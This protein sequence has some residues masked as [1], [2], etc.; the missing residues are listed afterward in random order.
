MSVVTIVGSQWGDEGKGKVV[1]L[2]GDR[3]D[4]IVRY[5]GGN[6]AG[7]TLV[8]GGEKVV[9]H[10]IPAA[11]L[12][13]DKICIIEAGVVLDP[14]VFLEEVKGLTD[15]G[16]LKKTK[17]YI[18]ER[19]HV[20]MPYHKMLDKARDSQGGDGNSPKIGT[21]GRGIGPC[22]SDKIARIG[23]RCGD[24]FEPELLKQKLKELLPEKNHLLQ[25]YGHQPLELD[26]LF[27]EFM[28][29]GEKLK[30]MITD[31][32]TIIREAAEAGKNILFEGAQGVLLDIDN[33]S[34]PYVTSS[35]TVAGCVSTGGGFSP[36]NVDKVVAI[37]KAYLTRVGEGPFPTE[38][39]NDTGEKLGRIGA[40]FG[41]TT[42]R[43][44]RCG[45]LDLVALNHAKHICGFNGL[46]LTKIDVLTSFAEL[47]VCVAYEID[48]KETR[49][50]PASIARLEKV[51]PVY[52]TFKGP[53]LPEGTSLGNFADFP[54]ELKDY[55]AFIE[56]ETKTKCYLISTGPDRA[57][58][59]EL[60]NPF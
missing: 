54:Q 23:I 48:G 25:F 21:T 16:Y 17:I 50:F 37:T 52:R 13:D 35:N 18:S 9:T 31:T 44:R 11:A 28:Q 58:V 34:Y 27:A 2:Y 53:D 42:G 55:V 29:I 43:K 7:H 4:V 20:I 19:T 15:R 38:Q 6:N 45:W 3:A 57:E 12:H 10:L 51:K 32:Q 46:A 41:A 30:P 40:E 14:L 8:V 36:G 5:Q 1:D 56:S 49:V 60:V 22:Y 24:F 33:G 47:K 26:T 59:D 39:L